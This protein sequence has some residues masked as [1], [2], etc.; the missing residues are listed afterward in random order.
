MLRDTL[1]QAGLAGQ[2]RLSINIRSE[3]LTVDT[4]NIL[5][6]AG[7]DVMLIGVESFNPT[8]L[9]R[10]Y[11]KRQDLGHLLK[12]VDA[13]DRAGVTTVASYILWHPWQTPKSLRYELEAINTF[14]RHRIPR[15]LTRSKLLVI[16]GTVVEAKIQHA[17][18]LE[19]GR[20][21][22][23]FYF[24]D[25]ETDELYNQFMDWFANH[26]A[27]V[28]TELTESRREDLT[29]L[30]KLKIAEWRWITH[31]VGLPAL[32]GSTGGTPCAI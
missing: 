5:A 27:P 7:V 6:E 15:F 16:P 18:L 2:L 28:L 17:G 21:H 10:L 29:T 12:V 4:V 23:R 31:A 3:T 20:F 14:G 24:A 13:A 32:A 22:R 26:V 1:R 11:G 30:A 9:H 19:T 8:T 25:P